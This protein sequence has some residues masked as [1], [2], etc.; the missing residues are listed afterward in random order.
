MITRNLK[1]QVNNPCTPITQE[2]M[3]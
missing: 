1:L 2:N 3:Y